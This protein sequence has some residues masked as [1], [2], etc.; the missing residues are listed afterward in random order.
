M[1]DDERMESSSA[2]N[3]AGMAAGE[4]SGDR[5]ERAVSKADWPRNGQAASG[6]LSLPGVTPDLFL[7]AGAAIKK[8]AMALGVAGDQIEAMGALAVAQG[9]AARGRPRCAT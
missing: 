7:E 1:S 6:Q 9:A 3:D 8:R 4:N 5:L 2:L